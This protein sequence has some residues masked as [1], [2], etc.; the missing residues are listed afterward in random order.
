MKSIE[1]QTPARIIA[2]GFMAVILT[3][4][5]LLMLPVCVKPGVNLHYVDA[6]FTSTSAV[7]VTGLI[8][9]DTADT[10]TA[11][12]QAIVAFLIQVGG[13]G[14]TSVGVGVIL[15]LGR[16][17]NL[18]ERLL[19]KEAMNLDSGKGIV[20]IVKNVLKTTLCFE[21]AGAVLSYLVF[22]RDYPP[23]KALGSACS[24][25]WLHLT[26]QALTFWEGFRI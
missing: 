3:G 8:A 11:L 18:K 2:L 15:A 5:F 7:C 25:R 20:C 9:V 1:K 26:I 6:L 13:L 4:S 21:G 23:L 14:V 12:G 17:V 19:I 22:S 10:Y 16:R 24:I